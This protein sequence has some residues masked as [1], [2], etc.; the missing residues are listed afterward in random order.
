MILTSSNQFGV[1]SDTRGPHMQKTTRVALDVET[2][3]V[4]GRRILEGISRYL[5]ASRPWSVYLEQ[6]E[7]GHDLRELMKRWNGDG[8]ITRSAAH[9]AV[10][11]LQR[12]H[13]AVIDLGDM[14]PPNEFMRIQSADPAI[15]AMAAKHLLERGFE[16]LA[17]C[18]FT[19]E[20]WSDRRRDGFVAEVRHQG[21]EPAIYESPR[22]GK[23]TWNRDQTELVDWI[24]K[25]P[26]PL[27][28][29]ATNDMRGQHVLDACQRLDLAVPESVA[30]VGVDNDEVLCGFCQP[31]LTSIIPDSERIGYEAAMWLDRI[32]SGDASAPAVVEVPPKGIAVR[33]SSDVYAV[34][35]ATVASALRFIRERA[36][37]GI[38]VKDVMD[39]VA[40]SRSWLERQFRKFVDHSPQA[41]IRS[42]QVRRCKELLKTT[43]LP[44]DK[45]AQ[46]TGFEHPEYMSVVFKR[47]TKETPGRYRK[48]HAESS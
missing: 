47:E 9:E 11:L 26:K 14:A 19:G 18:G 20:Y 25:L 7:L 33:Q 15:G 23:Q 39:H 40:V 48:R 42:V 1:R 41:E 16:S 5:R 46:L 27:G 4:Y 3:L 34:S 37:Q 12:R 29:F 30:V 2:A 17:C 22:L 43:P 35:D 38:S 45:I 31:P 44:L 6:H 13:L 21:F 24:E 8:I 10:A 32:M 36:C 28:V